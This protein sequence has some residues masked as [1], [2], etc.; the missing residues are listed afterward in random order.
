MSAADRAQKRAFLSSG[1]LHRTAETGDRALGVRSRLSQFWTPERRATCPQ[2]PEA[3]LARP[4]SPATLGCH[5]NFQK[6][7]PQPGW[8]LRANLSCLEKATFP[9]TS[10]LQLGENCPSL[11]KVPTGHPV[12]TADRLHHRGQRNKHSS[13]TLIATPWP[14]SRARGGCRMKT[15]ESST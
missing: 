13:C 2:G 8:T 6:D 5:P 3:F 14:G 9:T 10:H 7:H 15:V 11:H 12:R 4:R 1:R